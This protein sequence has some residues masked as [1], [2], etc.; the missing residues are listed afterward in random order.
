MGVELLE[1]A[2]YSNQQAAAANTGELEIDLPQQVPAGQTWRVDRIAAMVT[3]AAANAVFLET[4]LQPTLFVYDQVGPGPTAIPI[5]VT[6]LTPYSQA[7]TGVLGPTL[8]WLD[9]DDL[10]APIT[11]PAA[12]QLALL[13][14]VPWANT[15]WTA[16]ARIQYSR[17]G[18]TPGKPQPIAGAGP[19]PPLPPSR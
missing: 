1:Y 17:Y 14:F 2:L 19:L 9:A 13:F 18:G 11:I 15:A 16:F 5:D 6:N 8:Y 12:R 7:P 3:V 10:S 4:P